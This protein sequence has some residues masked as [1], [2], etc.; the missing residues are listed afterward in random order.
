MKKVT[1][2]ILLV[3]S[4]S[5]ACTKKSSNNSA[6]SANPS[7]GTMSETQGAPE[8]KEPRGLEGTWIVNETGHTWEL[9]ITRVDA[10]SWTSTPTLTATNT[11]ND[12][13]G[14]V[15]SKGDQIII[16]GDGP[17][18]F[19]VHYAKAQNFHGTEYWNGAGTYDDDTFNF[20]NY[21]IGKR[22][23]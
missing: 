9:V 10:N 12:F 17:G 16:V 11:P 18:K 1:T 22:K 19:K 4:L 20:A 3:L 7:S 6:T 23:S 21:Y 14:P 5:I 15:G 13:Y 8:K 2:V